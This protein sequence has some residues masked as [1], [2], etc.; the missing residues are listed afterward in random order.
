V[1]NSTCEG[2]LIFIKKLDEGLKNFQDTWI[3]KLPWEKSFLDDKGEIH[4][5]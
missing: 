2:S 3:T 4:Q 1:F 5:V